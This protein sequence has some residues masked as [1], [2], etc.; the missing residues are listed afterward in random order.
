MGRGGSDLVGILV[1]I[2]RSWPGDYSPWVAI[3]QASSPS[4]APLAPAAATVAPE[5]AL[6]GWRS[7]QE[8]GDASFFGIGKERGALMARQR[9]W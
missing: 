4:A 6:D 8:A 1:S 3:E 9:I 2:S 7:A 5:L